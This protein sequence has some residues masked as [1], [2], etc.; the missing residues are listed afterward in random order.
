M[1]EFLIKCAMFIGFIV[2][3]PYRR[4]INAE[5]GW[6]K[7]FHAVNYLISIDK[8]TAGEIQAMRLLNNKMKILSRPPVPKGKP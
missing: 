6:H 5:L 8:P 1:I 3:P 2:W 7:L 4:R